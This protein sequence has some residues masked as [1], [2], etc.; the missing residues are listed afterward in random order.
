MEFLPIPDADLPDK[1]RWRRNPD[2]P[3]IPDLCFGLFIPIHGVDIDARAKELGGTAHPGSLWPNHE[4]I[5]NYV[6]SRLR[7]G[8]FIEPLVAPFSWANW[9]K[10][11]GIKDPDMMLI[12]FYNNGD[13]PGL[14]AWYA[15]A[16]RNV[17]VRVLKEAF[18][19]KMPADAEPMWY[20][21]PCGK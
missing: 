9:A 11:K 16:R 21:D 10:S 20:L 3:N 17:L 5:I 4:I 18:G 6:M 13:G 19:P 15:G 14:R 8:A 1:F 12:V 2:D 7:R